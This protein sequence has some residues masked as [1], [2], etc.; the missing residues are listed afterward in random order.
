LRWGEAERVLA[1]MWLYEQAMALDLFAL[2]EEGFPCIS[3]KRKSEVAELREWMIKA[4]PVYAPHL[5][6]PPPWTSF[7]KTYDDGYRA[8]FVRDWRPETRAAID[9]AFLNPVWDHARGVNALARV[10]LKID[11]FM[12]RLVEQ[13]AVKLMGN[14]V[15]H[16]AVDLMGNEG[17]RRKIDE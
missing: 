2:D 13:F 7:E 4:D 1:G 14:E 10:P 8:K 9:I 6:P 11:P 16:V 5:K 3:D 15:E 12:V 17:V